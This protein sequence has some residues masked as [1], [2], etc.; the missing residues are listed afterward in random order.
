MCDRLVTE[1]LEILRFNERVQRDR[2]VTA[3]PFIAA[4]AVAKNQEDLINYDQ[5]LRREGKEPRIGKTNPPSE[6][7]SCP[8]RVVEDLDKL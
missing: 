6:R 7:R 5:F 4:T 3:E 1:R 2:L 8:S